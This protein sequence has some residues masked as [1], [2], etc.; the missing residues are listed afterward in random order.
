MTI[1]TKLLRRARE[2][3]AARRREEEAERSA[4]TAEV[5]RLAPR[6]KILDAELKGTMLDVIG[7]TLRSSGDVSAA[8]EDIREE[9][10]YL[11]SER[12]EELAAAGFPPDYLDEKYFCSKCHD[13]G[14]C[15][16]EM[17]I[18]LETLY[19]EEQ[20]RELSKMLNIGEE[21]FDHFDL[22][23]Y[24]PTPDPVTGISPR[25]SMDFVYETCVRYAE[26]FGKNAYN[27]FLNGGT[28]LGKTFLSSCIAKV[29]SERGFSVVYD[30]AGTIFT[31]FEEE[32]FSKSG[33]LSEARGDVKRYLTCD[34]LIVDDLGTELATAFVT[35]ALYNLINTRLITGKKTIIN[36]NLS[37]GEIRSRYSPQIVSRLEG[38]YQVLPFYGQDI[39]IQKK[40][41][42]YG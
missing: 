6:V 42:Q 9:N 19:A 7:H 25:R 39:R 4:R 16:G 31:R 24:D 41:R 3:L 10:L 32:K 2:R 33:D 1:D 37:M 36:S 17:C 38:E 26:K 29:V 34:L 28:G 18:C 13:T 12:A 27:L 20:R 14:Y 15:G 21:T 22:D 8:V 40:N 35:S 5:Y 11:Q 30:T 23:W